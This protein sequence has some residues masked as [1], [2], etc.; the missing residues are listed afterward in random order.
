MPLTLLPG[1]RFVVHM[2]MLVLMA[3][4]T[5]GARADN[6]LLQLR[7][8]PAPGALL[9]GRTLPGAHVTL[10]DEAVK[11]SPEGWFVVGFGRGEEGTRTLRLEHDN[12]AETRELVLAAREWNIQRIEGVPQETVTPPEELLAR[13]RKEAGKVW[14]ARQHFTT[15]Q[16]FLEPFAWPT[17]GPITGV[18][19]SQRFYNGEPKN[20]HY[21]IDIAAPEGT[22]VRAPVGGIVRLA[23][24]DL[25]YSGGTLIIDHGYG[26]SSTFLHLN[27]ILVK[28]GEEVT[29]GETVAEVGSTG[30]STG[31]HLDWRINWFG[32][33]LDPQWFM[34]AMDATRVDSSLSIA[35]GSAR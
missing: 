24:P 18:Y 17:S 35:E 4:L 23:E 29:Q 22:P 1:K 19:G 34:G 28:E 10:E 8:E 9:I 5:G 32:E 7:G 25:F 14:K 27:R 21:G 11:V 15:R 3:A 12:E 20:P 2:L 13:I 6:L 26:V 33:R 16:D 30:R 31:P